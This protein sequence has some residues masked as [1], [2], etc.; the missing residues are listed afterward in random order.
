MNMNGWHV[1]QYPDGSNACPAGIDH[2]RPLFGLFP[3]T[4]VPHHQQL[5]LART[6]ERGIGELGTGKG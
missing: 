5:C 2:L 6:L 4:P 1:V 3:L